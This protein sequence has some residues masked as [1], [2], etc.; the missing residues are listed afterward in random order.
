MGTGITLI[1]LGVLAYF[2]SSVVGAA[3]FG[4]SRRGGFGYLPQPHTGV[5]PVAFALIA[6]LGGAVAILGAILM[7][8]NL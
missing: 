5:V 1:L 6:L 3:F 8:A 4:L 2:G 7:L